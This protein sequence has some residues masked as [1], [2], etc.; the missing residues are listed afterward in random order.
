[1]AIL[2]DG[3]GKNGCKIKRQLASLSKISAMSPPAVKKSRVGARAPSILSRRYRATGATA[4]FLYILRRESETV[5][6]YTVGLGAQEQQLISACMKRLKEAVEEGYDSVFQEH[7]KWWTQFWNKSDLKIPDQLLEK[8]WYLG[9]Y[10]LGSCSRKGYYPM[11]LQ[12][13]WTADNGEL[14]P[15]KGDY[16]HDLNT[17]LCYSSYAKA[18]HLE[19]GEC[20]IDYLFQLEDQAKKFAAAYFEAPGMCLPGVMDYRAIRSA[21]G[22]CM[23]YHPPISSGCAI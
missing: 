14:P 11:P 1:M 15:W 4:F 21:G 2:T 20:L 13:V 12:G 5:A 9:N 19:E 6:A 22:R 17:E 7:A 23:L 16:H 10:L 18:N 3:I 8:N